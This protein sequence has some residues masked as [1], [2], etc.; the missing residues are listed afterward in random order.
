MKRDRLK[1]ISDQA[2]LRVKETEKA[3]YM[4]VK[5]PAVRVAEK[6]TQQLIIKDQVKRE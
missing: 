4:R 3:R 2:K 6:R 5:E 1:I